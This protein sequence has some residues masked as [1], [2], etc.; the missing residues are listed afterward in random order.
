MKSSVMCRGLLVAGAMCAADAAL[1]QCVPEWRPGPGVVGLNGDAIVMTHWDPDGGGPQAPMLI[2]AG[3]FT[4]AGGTTVNHIAAWNGEAWQALGAGTSH[5]VRALAVMP[6]TNEL[7]AGGDFTSVSG[8]TTVGIARW[9]GAAWSSLGTGMNNVVTGLAILPGGD[10]FVTGTF[11]SAGGV[12]SVRAARWNGSAWSAIATGVAASSFAVTPTGEVFAGG[13]FNSG[14]DPNIRMWTGP[15]LGTWSSVGGGLGGCFGGERVDEVLR[16]PGGDIIATGTFAV[17]RPGCTTTMRLIARWNGTAWT[18]MYTTD[19]ASSIHAIVLS[20]GGD[21]FLGSNWTNIWPGAGCAVFKQNGANWTTLA[22]FDGGGN[23]F[24]N[25]L[26]YAPDGTMYA[27]G[28]FTRYT[29]DGGAHWTGANYIAKYGA[30]TPLFVLQPVATSTCP[31]GSATFTAIA[32]GPG[33]ITYSWQR[34]GVPLVDEPDHISGAMTS[35]LTL[36]NITGAD[37]GLY[38]SVATNTC[39][40]S[41]SN[42]AALTICIADNDDGSFTGT[43]DGGVTIDDLLYYLARFDA[44]C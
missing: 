42:A 19:L 15:G 20:P 31:G 22:Y 36:V 30:P 16:L 32:T 2:V 25:A 27:C 13:N 3:V 6:N 8:V 5:T 41:S 40:G 12:S 9:N 33:T 18:E 17:T 24:I 37:A 14:T 34:D 11:T 44:G 28:R 7:I 39:G 10:L 29:I 26:E 21:L 35:S 43:T 23:P 4:M 1:G 38:R